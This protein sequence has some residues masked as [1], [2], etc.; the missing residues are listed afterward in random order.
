[1]NFSVVTQEEL[2]EH[3]FDNI[4]MPIAY[5]D[6]DF[7]FIRVNSTY[8]ATDEHGP[9]HFVGK[10]HFD[11]FPNAENEVI[12]RDVVKSGKSHHSKAKAFEYEKNPER[13]VTHWDWTLTPVRDASGKIAGVL[14]LLINVTEHIEAEIALYKK[15]RFITN[16]MDEAG[17]LIV[18]L[19][20]T[21]KITTFNKAAEQLSGYSFAEVKNKYVWDM[22]LIPEDIEPVKKIFNKIIK[23]TK[24]EY[25]NFW[26]A[27][28][29]KHYFIHWNNTFINDAAGNLEYIVS[30]G[31]DVTKERQQLIS[32]EADKERLD[33]ILSNSPSITYTC[34]TSGNFPVTYISSNIYTTF[35]YKQSECLNEPDWWVKNVH[36]DDKEHILAGLSALFEK[37]IHQHEYRFSKKNGEYRWVSDELKV[38]YDGNNQPLELLGS[39]SDIS[40]RKKN[41]LLLQR[42]ATMIDQIHDSVI[43]TDLDGNIKSWN[44]GAVRIFGFNDVEMLGKNISSIYPADEHEALLNEVIMPLKAKGSH[45]TESTM[46]RR[47]GERFIAHLS[48]SLLYDESGEPTGMIGYTMD[49]TERKL[50]EQELEHY[51]KNLEAQV[52]IRTKELSKAKEVA[53]H[54]NQLKSSFLNRMS[55]EL[56][57][58]MN[59]II[60]FSQLLKMEQISND[61]QEFVDEVILASEHLLSL[62]NEVL[63]L[64]RIES[65]KLLID[66]KPVSL[67]QTAAESVSFVKSI[68]EK[69][70]ITLNNEIT[71]E[72]DVVVYTDSVKLKEII[73]NFL[74]NAIKYNKKMGEVTLSYQVVNNDFV[75]IMVSDTG[76]GISIEN[77]IDIFEPF[78]RLGAEYTEIEG[79][80]V[81]LTIAKQLISLLGGKIGLESELNIGSTFWVECPISTKKLEKKE[82]VEKS[83]PSKSNDKTY[84]ILYI[85]DNPANL[86][87]IQF[88][89]EKYKNIEMLS[90]TNAEDGLNLA[91]EN[92]LDLIL[93]D[94]N[95]PGMDGYEALKQF[96]NDTKTK[97]IKVL[98][99]SASAGARD[100][101]KGLLAGFKRY[102]TK[103]IN[104]GE[105]IEIIK[106]EL[107]IEQAP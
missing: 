103:P 49:I 75:R 20:K 90:A 64:S 86:R 26:V 28:N 69:T 27:K 68:A 93:L 17:D 45:E 63:D 101:E 61:G 25:E 104:L 105:F 106:L 81:G 4:Y 98:A 73:V 46:L 16:I 76:K 15:N 40:E 71:T 62:I 34:S 74:T 3:L 47:S 82:K 1:M 53:E 57:T 80:G 96:Q 9:D 32:V 36:P 55:H 92:K 23:G 100:I 30:I 38:L 77:Q 59:A 21:G 65:G 51:Q 84:H 12:F 89:I 83:N 66:L 52:D 31:S 56:R 48:L 37:G 6:T 78:N 29:K 60:G 33:E 79:T 11:L 85:E 10:N 67:F 7:N 5:M 39:M 94:I 95:L 14:L 19:D 54:A 13:G 24:N 43:S 70:G 91:K 99:I 58:P 107:G 88:V 2:L 35:G 22:L 42:Q 8:A 41:E 87:L 102:L 97:D 18:V 50:I 44:K 72:N